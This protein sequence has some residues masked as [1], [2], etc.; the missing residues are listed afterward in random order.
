MKK[1]GKTEKRILKIRVFFIA[2]AVFLALLGTLTIIGILNDETRPN[3]HAAICA[4]PFV[5]MIIFEAVLSFRVLSYAF[6]IEFGDHNTIFV[7]GFGNV[8][9]NN[10]DVYEVSVIKGVFAGKPEKLTI[11]SN[12]GIKTRV[13]KYRSKVF[14]DENEAFEKCRR[15]FDRAVFIG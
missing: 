3:W 1:P 11:K 6:H 4:I 2:S 7:T 8:S 14:G 12:D 15:Y 5:V 10:N 13:F 9:V